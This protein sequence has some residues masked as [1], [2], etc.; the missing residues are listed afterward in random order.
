[1]DSSGAG[2]FRDVCIDLEAELVSSREFS[3]GAL[4]C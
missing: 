4:N 2:Y 3:K 1:M